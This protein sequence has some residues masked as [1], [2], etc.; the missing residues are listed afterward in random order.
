[1]SS[2][3]A[4]LSSPQIKEGLVET[5][6]RLKVGP[7]TEFDS[8]M[9]AVIDAKSFSRVKGYVEGAKSGADTDILAGGKCDDRYIRR[10]GLMVT[11][12]FITIGSTD[13][14]PMDDYL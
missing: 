14:P 9:S 10:E 2:I 4:T 5:Q 7:V 8:F 1:M 3:N 13:W 12:V 6:K 11:K